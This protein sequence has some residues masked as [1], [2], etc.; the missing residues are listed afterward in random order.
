MSSDNKF[1]SSLVLIVLLFSTAAWVRADSAITVLTKKQAKA[2]EKTATTPEE[3]LALAGYFREQA[4]ALDQRILYHQEM[5]EL[6][7]R[8]PLPFDGKSAV[9]MQRHCKDLEWDYA[10]KAE[11]A[12]V[13]TEFHEQMALGPGAPPNML[14]NL[15]KLGLVNNG[16]SRTNGDAMSIDATAAQSALYQQWEASSAHFYD[17]TRILTYIVSA[18]GT[19]LADITELKSAASTMF[20]S[21]QRFAQS[22]TEGQKATLGTRLQVIA[23][24][25]DQSEHGLLDLGHTTA[26]ATSRSYFNTAKQIKKNVESWHAIQQEIADRLHIPSWTR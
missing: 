22:L 25:Q 8:N 23:R 10:R 2:L 26:G 6:Y 14:N 17:L 20:D 15:T 4:H 3:H 18:K 21:Q 5:A 16:F 1:L 11:R 12:R 7:Q 13:L 9:P 24:L 19:P